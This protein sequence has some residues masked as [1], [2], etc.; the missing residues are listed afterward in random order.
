MNT[1]LVLGH[2]GQGKSEFV[3]EYIGTDKA[4]LVM[5]IQDEYGS[6]TKYPGQKAINLS[7]NNKERRSRYIGGDFKIYLNIVLSKRKTICVFEEATI[8]LEGR[9]MDTM[10]RVLVNKMFTQNVYVLCFHS[11]C[12]VPPRILQLADY[13]VLYKTN[14]E[15]YQV[16]RKYPSLYIDFL[17]TKEY[18]KGQYKT[19][20]R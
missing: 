3:K 6:R 9:T 14:D 16:E 2:T 20:K 10:R 11:I 12:A 13:I 15:E 4:C 19:I 1:I 7:T 17:E 8:F 18:E 5:D